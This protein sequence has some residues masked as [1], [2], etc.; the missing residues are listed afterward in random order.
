MLGLFLVNVWFFLEFCEK[1]YF[2]K[3]AN[4]NIKSL[5][6]IFIFVALLTHFQS[7]QLHS[8]LSLYGVPGCL[9][10]LGIQ[11]LILAQ[12]MISWL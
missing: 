3:V 2:E 7:I 9:S 12:V 5:P 4:L 10:Q 6:R 1:E 8:I 11:V